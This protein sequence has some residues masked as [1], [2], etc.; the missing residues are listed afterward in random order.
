VVLIMVELV[1]EALSTRCGSN[2]RVKIR[3]AEFKAGLG[4][5]CAL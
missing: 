2:I 3:F 5:A 1:D 4:T